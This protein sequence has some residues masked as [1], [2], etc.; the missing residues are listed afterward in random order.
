M[1]SMSD[2]ISDT[3]NDVPGSDGKRNRTDYERELARLHVEFVKL[4]Q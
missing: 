2:P 4:D 3:K 1:D